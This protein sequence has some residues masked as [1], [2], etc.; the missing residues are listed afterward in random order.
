[1]LYIDKEREFCIHRMLHTDKCTHRE[2]SHSECLLRTHVRG[3]NT[4]NGTYRNEGEMRH[5]FVG[6]CLF[7]DLL[8]I[9]CLFY[10]SD[11]V[12]GHQMH[13]TCTDADCCRQWYWASVILLV[14]CQS[15]CH[16]ASLCTHSWM[17][18][19]PAWS[20][21]L[22]LKKH[23]I[24]WEFWFILHIWCGLCQLLWPLVVHVLS[25]HCVSAW[26]CT[27]NFTVG[28]TI[29]ST[30]LQCKFLKTF[31]SGYRFELCQISLQQLSFVGFIS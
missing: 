1:M 29:Y 26:N 22:G 7:M 3:T 8:M 21:D 4:A 9:F 27:T 28:I 30:L 19:G 24:R 2:C 13:E 6:T 15:A 18:W 16:V 10:S 31:N 25:V 11:N 20:G 14:N 17:Y 23:C 12:T 5:L